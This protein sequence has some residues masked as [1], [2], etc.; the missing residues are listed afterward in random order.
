MLLG[1]LALGGS[2][3]IGGLYNV[4]APLFCDLMSAFN[5]KNLP[6]AQTLQK[7]ARDLAALYLEFGASPATIKAMLKISGIDCGPARLPL[8][9]LPTPEYHRL[10]QKLDDIGFFHFCTS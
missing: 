6:K 4:A 7:K 10:E 3:A 9:N 5:S 2:G 1:A 8:R